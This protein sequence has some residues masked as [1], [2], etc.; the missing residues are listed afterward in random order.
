MADK[1]GIPIIGGIDLKASFAPSW[2][3]TTVF[4]SNG[5]IYLGS[6]PFSSTSILQAPPEPIRPINLVGH[7]LSAY[8]DIFYDRIT[9]TPEF[10]NAGNIA[11]D[12]EYIITIFNAYGESKSLNSIDATDTTGITITNINDSAITFPV[13]ILSLNTVQFKITISIDGPIVIDASYL[14]NFTGT[15][16]D[17]ILPITGIRVTLFNYMYRP[18]MV[19]TLEWSTNILKSYNGTEQ[20]IKLRQA[21]RQYIKGTVF[22]TPS[23]FMKIDNLLYN[24]RDRLWAVPIFSEQEYSTAEITAGSFSVSVNTTN[25]DYY[26]G[27][28]VVLYKSPTEFFISEVVAVFTTSLTLLQAPSITFPIGTIVCP[29]KVGIFSRDPIRNTTGWNSTVDVNFEIT[30]YLTKT[31]IS[32]PTQ[33][34]DLDV[35]L[36]SDFEVFKQANTQKMQY[37]KKINII[38][39]DTGIINYNSPYTYLENI[40]TWRFVLEGLTEIYN[41]KNWLYKLSGRV[42]PFWLPSHEPNFIILSTGVLSSIIE[43]VNNGY[44]TFASIRTTAIFILKNGTSLIREIL[45]SSI[46]DENTV[47][48]NLDSALGITKEEI[49]IGSYLTK[50]R[51][52]TD[53]IVFNW[54]QNFCC[55]VDVPIREL[56]P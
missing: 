25:S 50:S 47:Q 32:L 7:L 8:G 41:F 53:K 21:P 15:V 13:V 40:R 54:Y 44:V 51:L 26:I 3:N 2:T 42:Y 17:K 27:G 24:W 49:E 4:N 6:L 43:V 48:I 18:G 36:D 46:I 56:Q 45:S 52:D 20:R 12:Q 11:L 29:A 38:D 33:Y 5:D 37:F 10:I 28:I 35:L 1:N 16:D 55:T 30:E 23:E 39:Y 19:E 14:F 34:E 22:A 9:I 31:G